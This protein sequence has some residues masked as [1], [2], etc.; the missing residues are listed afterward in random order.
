MSRALRP[1]R[2][3]DR[4][5]RPSAQNPAAHRKT[6]PLRRTILRGSSQPLSLGSLPQPLVEDRH[7]D[8]RKLPCQRCCQCEMPQARAPEE[9]FRRQALDILWFRTDCHQAPRLRLQ[10]RTRL[11]ELCLA[12][13]AVALQAS[14]HSQRF[15]TA[16]RGQINPVP[17][18][19]S[20]R[21]IPGPP[22]QV[23]ASGRHPGGLL[24]PAPSYQPLHR[25]CRSHRAYC[26]L[27]W[28]GVDRM[29]PLRS[30]PAS[31]RLFR[32]LKDLGEP[33]RIFRMARWTPLP[34][35]PMKEVV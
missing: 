31:T 3:C 6:P 32:P 10:K 23:P 9:P 1:N 17:E 7:H 11:A 19:F 25:G 12:Q 2:H 21:A 16:Q 26:S 5:G 14:Q 18:L 4:Q 35:H 24:L 29:G 34:I 13:E 15:S 33:H 22:P 28:Q 8:L 30:H 20:Q 27:S